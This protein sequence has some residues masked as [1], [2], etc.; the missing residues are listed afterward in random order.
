M[1][2]RVGQESGAVNWNKPQ[3]VAFGH[4]PPSLQGVCHRG[5][6]AGLASVRRPRGQG[7]TQGRESVRLCSRRLYR[8][9][10][11]RVTREQFVSCSERCSP[12]HP[13]RPP[14]TLWFAF[15]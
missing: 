14:S 6:V 9:A 7:T 4:T 5:H 2:L 8:E 13:S 10:H 12:L 1:H 11:R 15:L 3:G